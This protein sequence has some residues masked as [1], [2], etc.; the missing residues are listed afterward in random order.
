M[1][2]YRIAKNQTVTNLDAN[3]VYT[4]DEIEKLTSLGGVKRLLEL[5]AIEETADKPGT[6]PVPQQV[7]PAGPS[8]PSAGGQVETVNPA[9]LATGRPNR[10]T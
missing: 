5:K 10:K 7:Q 6:A 9:N 1:P 4:A 3:R 2:N 8:V